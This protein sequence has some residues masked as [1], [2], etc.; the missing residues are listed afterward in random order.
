LLLL[1]LVLVLVWLALLLRLLER[2][3]AL[4]SLELLVLWLGQALLVMSRA[5]L[6]RRGLAAEVAWAVEGQV[7]PSRCSH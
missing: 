6:K 3:L 7:Y 5:R 4:A 1:V 2:L